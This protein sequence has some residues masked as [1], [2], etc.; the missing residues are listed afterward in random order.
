MLVSEL[1]LWETVAIRIC[2]INWIT[3]LSV[4]AIMCVRVRPPRHMI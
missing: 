3:S 4:I 1:L 2:V